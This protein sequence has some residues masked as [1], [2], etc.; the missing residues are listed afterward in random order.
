MVDLADIVSGGGSAFDDFN[1]VMI[2]LSADGSQILDL[3]D[4]SQGTLIGFTDNTQGNVFWREGANGSYFVHTRQDN[5]PS[6]NILDQT[7][8]PGIFVRVVSVPE[9]STLGLLA[10]GLIGFGLMRRRRRA[11]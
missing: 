1:D 9:P 5:S 11:A 4:I 8:I 2:V 10:A 7:Q 6:P 3:F